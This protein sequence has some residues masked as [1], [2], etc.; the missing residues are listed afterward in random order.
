MERPATAF[1]P[2]PYDPLDD[3]YYTPASHPPSAV[4]K[5]SAVPQMD[6]EDESLSRISDPELPAPVLTPTVDSSED[7]LRSIKA[8]PEFIPT[9]AP[10]GLETETEKKGRPRPTA[11]RKPQPPSDPVATKSCQCQLF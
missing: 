4:P 6:L 3:P 9:P 11:S 2:A 8:N 7:P 5:S 10:A 1:T